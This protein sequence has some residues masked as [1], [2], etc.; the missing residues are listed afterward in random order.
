MCKC[1]QLHTGIRRISQA[2]AHNFNVDSDQV[3]IACPA[4]SRRRPTV[5]SLAG[6]LRFLV[7]LSHG[8]NGSIGLDPAGGNRSLGV[9]PIPG[10]RELR[11]GDLSLDRNASAAATSAAHFDEAV[12]MKSLANPQKLLMR[13]GLR[14]VAESRS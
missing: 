2:A 10:C 3:S 13:D 12:V 8:P 1:R 9:S 7:S 11:I 6:H 4:R 14:L 5:E